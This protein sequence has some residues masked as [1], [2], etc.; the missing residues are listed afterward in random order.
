MRIATFSGVILA[1]L[2]LVGC[3]ASPAVSGPTLPSPRAVTP[4]PTWTPND[5]PL[6]RGTPSPT[7]TPDETTLPAASFGF[8]FTYG[9][10]VPMRVDTFAGTFSRAGESADPPVTVPLS[11]LPEDIQRIQ[12]DVDQ[13]DFF[14][15]P[16]DFTLPASQVSTTFTPATAYTFQVREGGRRHTVHWLDNVMHV[17][18]DQADQLRQ[19]ADLI[20]RTAHGSP[21]VAALPA[22]HVGCA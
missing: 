4:R 11:L 17:S 2:L 18:S 1:A 6:S 3:D 8:I 19:L 20:E 10:C 14:S 22:L 13:I 7:W 5:Q 12:R 16:S 21:A 9:A 15:Y